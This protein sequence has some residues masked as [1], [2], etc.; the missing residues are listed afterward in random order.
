MFEFLFSFS[1]DLIWHHFNMKLV[2]KS[3]PLY[4]DLKKKKVSRE[5][6]CDYTKTSMTLNTLCRV[7]HLLRFEQVFCPLQGAV[8]VVLKGHALS[9]ERSLK[10]DTATISGASTGNT[11]WRKIKYAVTWHNTDTTWQIIAVCAAAAAA[12]CQERWHW[13]LANTHT[14]T[15]CISAYL[16][17]TRVARVCVGR[18]VETEVPGECVLKQETAAVTADSVSQ[19]KPRR[20]LPGLAWDVRSTVAALTSRSAS[21][22]CHFDVTQAR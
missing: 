16:Q 17:R 20:L 22:E 9:I 1:R 6:T 19:T 15:P 5:V 14:R 2:H 12:G 10:W 13:Q 18:G 4:W 21:W 8:Y 7:F 3:L 11:P